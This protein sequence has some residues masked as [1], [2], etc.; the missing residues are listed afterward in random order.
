VSVMR[1][2]G[3]IVRVTRVEHDASRVTRSVRHGRQ[4]GSGGR[5]GE[6]R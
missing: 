4:E 1:M 5:P 2:T 3:V 6:A